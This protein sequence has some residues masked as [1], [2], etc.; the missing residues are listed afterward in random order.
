MK[1]RDL[2]AEIIQKISM[3][4]H[5]KDESCTIGKSVMPI[6]VAGNRCRYLKCEGVTFMVQNPMKQTDF[7]KLARRGYKIVWGMFPGKWMY[8][9]DHVQRD[10]VKDKELCKG[11]IAEEKQI[12]EHISRWL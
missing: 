11:I 2:G 4:L 8:I 6:K 12:E 10:P 9:R 7:A 3:S 1:A 5:S